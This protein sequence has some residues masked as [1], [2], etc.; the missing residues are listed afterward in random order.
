MDR[1]DLLKSMVAAGA[2]AAGVP[3]PMAG[4]QDG[5]GHANHELEGLGMLYDATLCIGCKVC[6]VA[7][8]EANDVP[9]PEDA[10]LYYDPEDLSANCITIIKLFRGEEE[11]SFV[12]RQCMH[13]VDPACVAACPFTAMLKRE[14]GVVVWDG[15]RCVGCRYC[16]IGCPF[17]IPKFEWESRNPKIVKCELCKHRLAEGHEPACV[18]ECPRDAI[19][20]GPRQMLL[21]EARRRIAENPDRYH[22]RIYGEDEAGGTQVLYISQAGVDPGELGFPALDDDAL[23]ENVRKVQGLLYKGFVAP[24]ALYAAL[25]TIVSR[26]RQK[27]RGEDE[28]PEHARHAHHPE[29]DDVDA[30]AGP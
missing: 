12:K 26:N 5:H 4:A 8:R 1:R 25:G 6:M 16:E 30:E 2:A 17:N 29:R 19:L 22:P 20:F 13:C 28:P 15:D 9:Y 21:N 24:L 23:P 10:E 3:S 7:C 11:F 14:D 18:E 27:A